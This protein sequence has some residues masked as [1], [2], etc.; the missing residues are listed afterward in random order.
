MPVEKVTTL[1]VCKVSVKPTE[2]TNVNITR[3]GTT[4]AEV[5]GIYPFKVRFKDIGYPGFSSTSP[6]SI[7]IAVIGST[8]Y[9][10]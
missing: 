4:L 1:E 10:L 3:I 5:Q 6:P 7:G 9:I 2:Y 8:F